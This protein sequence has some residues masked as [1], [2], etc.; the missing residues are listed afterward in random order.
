MLWKELGLLDFGQLRRLLVP[1][2][3]ACLLQWPHLSLG[4]IR[5]ISKRKRLLG[6]YPSCPPS[7][8]P[9]MLPLS[10]RPCNKSAAN[11]VLQ[12]WMPKL[13]RT[14]LH[15]RWEYE[16]GGELGRT[17]DRKTGDHLAAHLSY[18]LLDFTCLHPTFRW[19]LPPLDHN[20][21]YTQ[22]FI[23]C[24]VSSDMMFWRIFS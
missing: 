16:E 23:V 6:F 3:T 4:G 7:Y 12:F 18:R 9:G 10:C 11:D 17:A 21:A 24:I 8:L 15:G 1:P 19:Q 20:T 22:L 5:P 2:S 13:L 14:A